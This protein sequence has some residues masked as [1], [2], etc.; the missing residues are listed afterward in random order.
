MTKLIEREKA[1]QLRKQGR[2]YSE[3]RKSLNV[4]KSTLSEWL[5]NYPLSKKQLLILQNRIR[6]N[7]SIAVEKVTAIKHR[8]RKERLIKVYNK[9]RKKLLPLNKRELLLCGLFL[10]WGEGNKHLERAISLNNTDPDVVKFYHIWLTEA[11]QIPKQKIKV[12]LQLYRD[13]DVNKTINY[14]S[15]LLDIPVDQ[16]I[17]PYIKLSKRIG[18]SHK[19]FGYGTCGL[20][21]HNQKLKEKIMLGIKSIADYYSYKNFSEIKNLV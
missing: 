21:T 4:P 9:E 19:G 14:W 10:Y 20:Y 6:N 2:T 3:I 5:S 13:M 18:L 15:R 16:F 1:I 17:K 12:A 8:K 7:K 11:L